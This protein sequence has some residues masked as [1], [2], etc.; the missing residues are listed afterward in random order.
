MSCEQCLQVSQIIRQLTCSPLQNS[1]EYI[2]VQEDAMPFYLVPGLPP[3]GGNENIVTA[4]NIISRYLFAY[5]T[6]NRDAKTVGQVIFNIMTK[7]SYLPTTLISDKGTAF[8]SHEIKEVAGVLGITLKHAT[9]KQAQTIGLLGQSLTSIK[10]T[11]KIETG[12]WRSFCFKYVSLGVL[13]YNTTYQLCIGCE[14]S[15]VFHVCITYNILDSK[16]DIF[17]QRTPSADSQTAQDVPK[18]TEMIFQEIR[19][20]AMQAYIKYKAYY[21]K[22]SQCLKTQTSRLRLHPTAKSRSPRKQNS[23]DR[24]PVDWTLYF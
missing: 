16:I 7:H 24:F 14:P 21:D 17:P 13:N 8:L 5:P 18:Q 4:M 15:R 6:Y 23:L 11:L 3:S 10:K 2:I 12:E 20:N 19:K 22:K 1:N 9:T